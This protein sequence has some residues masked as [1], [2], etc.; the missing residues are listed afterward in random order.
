MAQPQNGESQVKILS[1]RPSPPGGNTLAH[2]D[3]ELIDGAKLFGLRV[4]RADDGTYRVFGQNSDRGRT[5]SF[6]P[7]IVADIAAATISQLTL[8]GHRT[9]DQHAS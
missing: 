4:S 7:A 2:V 9:N 3:V 1:I 6:S 8:T 5:C